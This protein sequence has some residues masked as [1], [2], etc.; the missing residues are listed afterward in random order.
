MF[1]RKIKPNI[2]AYDHTNPFVLSTET[3]RKYN[4]HAKEICGRNESNFG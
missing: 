3:N 4:I 2:G 1:I